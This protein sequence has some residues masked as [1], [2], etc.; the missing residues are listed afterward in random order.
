MMNS[1][2][3]K[4]QLRTICDTLP[5]VTFAAI[6]ENFFKSEWG[7]VRGSKISTK[8]IILIKCSF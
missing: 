6:F 8:L 5:E 3:M 4:T 2:K 7:W 1:A